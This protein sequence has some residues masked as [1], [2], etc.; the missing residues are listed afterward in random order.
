MN[1]VFKNEVSLLGFWEYMFQILFRVLPAQDCF[2]KS[3]IFLTQGKMRNIIWG[4]EEEQDVYPSCG[5]SHPS[6]RV[7]QPSRGIHKISGRMMSFSGLR[8]CTYIVDLE[9]IKG[10]AAVVD[11]PSVGCIT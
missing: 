10:S 11:S 7:S 8:D 6:G 1:L 9:P 3:P 4:H 5:I 2:Q